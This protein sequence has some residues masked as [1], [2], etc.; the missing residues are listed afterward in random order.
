MKS[1]IYKATCSILIGTMLWTATNGQ[2]IPDRQGKSNTIQKPKFRDS[3][4]PPPPRVLVCDFEKTNRTESESL[5]LFNELVAWNLKQVKIE[6]TKQLAKY[7]P[8]LAYKNVYVLLPS[9]D[10]LEVA[11]RTDLEALKELVGALDEKVKSQNLTIAKL[12]NQSESKRKQFSMRYGPNFPP[13]T[14]ISVSCSQTFKTQ[15]DGKSY[16]IATDGVKSEE[17]KSIAARTPAYALS[18]DA[19]YDAEAVEFRKSETPKLLANY[20]KAA[21]FEAVE[22]IF[23]APD[24]G[25]LVSAAAAEFSR[26]TATVL[27]NYDDSK[28]AMIE[29]VIGKSAGKSAFNELPPSLAAEVY[30]DLFRKG[31]PPEKIRSAEFQLDKRE[32]QFT[33]GVRNS[34]GIAEA[35][36]YVAF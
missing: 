31:V 29:K 3:D 33:V 14:P 7:S 20:R 6:Q 32:L 23:S 13:D 2:Q 21:Q 24:F 10:K 12:F 11:L 27:K 17:L 15:I 5:E 16:E 1:F 36:T 35:V 18:R 19:K 4:K 22:S 9:L 25:K 28:S 34:R 8:F 30:M 26:R